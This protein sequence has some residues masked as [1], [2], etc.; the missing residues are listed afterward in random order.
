[1]EITQ[2]SNWRCVRYRQLKI[3]MEG[4][5]SRILGDQRNL[6]V[7]VYMQQQLSLAPFRLNKITKCC[8]F[9]HTDQWR[10]SELKPVGTCGASV[11]FNHLQFRPF[12]T[13]RHCVSSIK[14][15]FSTFKMNTLHWQRDTKVVIYPSAWQQLELKQKITIL[16]FL[17][18]PLAKVIVSRSIDQLNIIDFFL[19]QC[20]LHNKNSTYFIS[21]K[22]LYIPFLYCMTSKQFPKQA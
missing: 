3:H 22:C 14:H 9:R 10:S 17:W 15:I 4:S 19:M 18:M 16:I 12:A 2:Y 8:R 5:W 7:Q 6:T 13:C 21:W 20:I 11:W 1:M